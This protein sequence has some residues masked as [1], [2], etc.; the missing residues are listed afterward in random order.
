MARKKKNPKEEI[1]VSVA[2]LAQAV[3][4]YA[5]RDLGSWKSIAKEA[6]IHQSTVY[7]IATGRTQDPRTSTLLA[8][9]KAGGL[10]LRMTQNGRVLVEV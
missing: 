6:N 3:L 8:L 4:A 5:E 7:Y 10:K 1:L 9:C 2:E